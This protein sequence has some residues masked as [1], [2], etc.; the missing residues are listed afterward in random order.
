MKRKTPMRRGGKVKARNPERR[1][2][3]FVRTYGSKERVEWVKRQPCTVPFCGHSPSE[4][5]HVGPKGKG[6]GR[7]ADADQI[8]PLCTAHHGLLHQKGPLW[9]AA[10]TGV[11]PAMLLQAAE[12][13]EAG[14]KAYC[15]EMAP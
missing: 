15:G 4:N 12:A 11:S 1:T 13:T 8:A 9:F 6:V 10:V 2:A 7:K 5:A 3:E 14:W